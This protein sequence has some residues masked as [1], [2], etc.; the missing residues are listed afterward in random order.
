MPL[1]PPLPRSDHPELM[2]AP[3]HDPAVLRDNLDD[4]RRV[5]RWLAGSALTRRALARLIAG[6][7][8]G[9]PLR[10]LDVGTGGAD[11]PTGLAAWARRRGLEPLVVALD[12]SPEILAVA[13]RSDG[14]RLAAGDARRLPFASGS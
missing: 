9:A 10:L 1:L 12:L 4:L 2:D 6:L 13:V 5:N 14:V 7:P 11:I 3:G 8:R